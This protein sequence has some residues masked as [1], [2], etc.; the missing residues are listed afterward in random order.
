MKK[1]IK[2]VFALLL[3]LAMLAGVMAGCA[4]KEEPS[5]P[6]APAA[7]K[8]PEESKKEDPEKKPAEKPEE[9]PAEKPEEKPAEP[10][11]KDLVLSNTIWQCDETGQIFVFYA[12]ESVDWSN[13]AGGELQTGIYTWEGT[14]GN[15]LIDDNGDTWYM[16]IAAQGENLIL[17]WGDEAYTYQQ[18][19]A[20]PEG[21]DA[22]PEDIL[23]LQHLYMPEEDDNHYGPAC[24]SIVLEGSHWILAETDYLF[25]YDQHVT[26]IGGNRKLFSGT[27]L[28]DGVQGSMQLADGEELGLTWKDGGLYVLDEQGEEYQMAPWTDEDGY[29]EELDELGGQEDLLVGDWYQ[30]SQ[31]GDLSFYEGGMGT[32]L[33]ESGQKDFGYTFNGYDVMLLLFDD[34]G[35]DTEVWTGVIMPE[36][37]I[38][39]DQTELIYH[40]KDLD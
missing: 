25:S 1:S 37:G 32:I 7:E 15:I 6:D 10:E 30:E 24:E 40:Q 31:Y 20:L 4:K 39:F 16:D 9:K 13:E 3:L 36:G 2:T 19:D 28:W 23:S 35:N 29:A 38:K 12:D 5:K 8:K 21:Y 34:E 26:V 14:G 22:E 27:F 11:Q 18:L 17:I 33:L